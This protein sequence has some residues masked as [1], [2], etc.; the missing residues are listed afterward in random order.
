MVLYTNNHNCMD[1]SPTGLTIRT[2]VLALLLLWAQA[3]MQLQRQHRV[4]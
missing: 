2:Y 4:Y 3:N 1:A